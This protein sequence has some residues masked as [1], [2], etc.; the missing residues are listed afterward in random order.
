MPLL[1]DAAAAFSAAGA[2][3]WAVRCY[4]RMASADPAQAR[5]WWLRVRR[6]ADDDPAYRV[7]FG[8]DCLRLEAFGPGLIICDGHPLRARLHNAERA[9]FLLALAG[10]DGM[11]TEQLADRLW[12]GDR[13][14]RRKLLGRI[15]TLLWEL[16]HALGSQAWRLE[17]DGPIVRLD[18]FGIRFDLGEARLAARAVSGPAALEIAERLRGPLLTRW[19]YEDWV[20]QEHSR[21]ILI[22]DRIAGTGP[23]GFDA[24]VTPAA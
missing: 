1:C 19:R 9:L 17:R 10:R 2:R 15:R 21:N 23:D 18:T 4:A 5:D 7:L 24:G 16:R 3:Y 6:G 22:A 13:I 8:G 12:A 14:E 20:D 11:H